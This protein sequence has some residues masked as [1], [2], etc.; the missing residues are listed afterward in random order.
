MKIRVYYEDTDIGG[1]VYYANYLKFCERARSNIFF[2]RGLSPHN[3]DEFFVV[4]KVEADYIKSATFADEL[5][6]TSKVVSQKSASLEI[7][8]EIFRGEE[9]LFTAKV[10]L[11]YLKNYKPT[12][13][14]KET[15]ELFNEFK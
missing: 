4:K 9:L 12:K 3:G 2:E 10:K 13:I 6:V 7:F 1:V 11:A 5:E 15:L 8:H 14:P